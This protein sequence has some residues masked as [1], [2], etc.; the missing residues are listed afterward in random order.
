MSDAPF[1]LVV[2]DHQKIRGHIVLQLRD[3]GFA[4][5]AVTSAEAA[6]EF[7]AANEP[8]DLLLVDVRL[9][10]MSGIDLVRGLIDTQRMPPTIVI[11]GEAS[12]S[13]TVEA[14]RL[15]VYDFIEKPFT[16]ER[17]ISALV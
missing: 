14:L 15:G 8:P 16:R 9:P 12:I 4:V 11:S 10:A 7:L 13:E 5:N 2:E 3:Q 1:I 6:L 17:L